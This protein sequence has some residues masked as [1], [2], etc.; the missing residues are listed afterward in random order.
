M[1]FCQNILRKSQ[2]SKNLAL[3]LLESL[4]NYQQERKGGYQIDALIYISL[5]THQY[6]PTLLNLS[7]KLHN[8]NWIELTYSQQQLQKQDAYDNA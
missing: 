7:P 8:E 4:G 2:E 1:S 5:L 6:H 3:Q